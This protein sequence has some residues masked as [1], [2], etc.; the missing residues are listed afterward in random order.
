MKILQFISIL[1]TLAFIFSGSPVLAENTLH[2]S[3]KGKDSNDGSLEAPFASFVAARD[4]I[5][6]VRQSDVVKRKEPFTVVIHPGTYYF[7]TTF[8]LGEKEYDTTWRAAKNGTVF[9]SGSQDISAKKVTALTEDEKAGIISPEARS[10]ILRVDLSE[11]GVTGDLGILHQRGFALPYRP[12]Q[13]ELSINGKAQRLARWPNVGEPR[14]PIL[15][16]IDAGSIPRNGDYSNRG[17]KIQFGPDRIKSW[18]EAD[19]AWI[20]GYFAHGYSDDSVKIKDIDVEKK[21]IETVQPSRYGFMSGASWRSFYGFN[22]FAEIDQPGEYYIDRKDRVLYFYPP[23]NFDPDS[24]T[25]NFSFMRE[26]LVA[27]E[28]TRNVQIIGITFEN[29]GGMGVYL[30][31]TRSC[32]IDSCTLRNI[33]LVAVVIGNGVDP[34]AGSYNEFHETVKT[35]NETSR[36]LGSI[37][38]RIYAYNA[39][40]R[41][42]GV[43]NSVTNCDIY[44][45]GCGGLHIGGG[46]FKSLKRAKNRVENCHIR[47]V[48]RVEKTYRSAI[49]ITGVGHIIRNN[50]IEDTVQSAIYFHGNDHLIENNEFRRCLTYGDDHG[51]I[52]YGRNPAELGTVIRHNIF[53]DCA[54]GHTSNSPVIYADDGACGLTVHNNLFIRSGSGFTFLLGGGSFHNIYNNVFIE[55]APAIRIGNRMQTWS[56][57]LLAEGG[58]F[59][60]RLKDVNF[61]RGVYATRYPF[62]VS[63]LDDSPEIPKGN[64]F[65]SNI[66]WKTADGGNKK[67]IEFKGNYRA[68]DNPTSF[69]PSERK[70]SLVLT[71]DMK[72]ILGDS[73]SPPQFEK[74]GLRATPSR[75][76]LPKSS[77]K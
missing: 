15:R 74:M 26:P 14:V 4:A 46:E 2:V 67:Y 40:E 75:P 64:Q 54:R 19:D 41:R 53:T 27:I 36:V 58:L 11:S 10:E 32:S 37:N 34:L 59:R 52:Y 1:I 73:F 43:D 71:D 12:M 39:F 72:S 55:C 42:G 28:K 35:L 77:V 70:W 21:T 25:L 7:E 62:L 3:I 50:L 47:R 51:V 69:I 49:N 17:G 16:V 9:I 13:T 8:E 20:Y 68:V 24:S 65:T 63:Y 48:N 29:T 61:N 38:E 44:D 60:S 57:G 23:E 33:G 6:Q 30:E 56:K 5:R 66:L 76:L 31:D 22:I 45:I 18:R